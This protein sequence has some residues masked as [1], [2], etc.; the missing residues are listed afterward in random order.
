MTEDRY[1]WVGINTQVALDPSTGGQADG[2]GFAIH[3]SVLLDSEFAWYDATVQGAARL[4]AELYSTQVTT[5]QPGD[6]R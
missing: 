6:G 4:L 5:P 3:V 1:Y 2:M